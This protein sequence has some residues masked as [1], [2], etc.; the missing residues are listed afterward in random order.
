MEGEEPNVDA[1]TALGRVLAELVA[2]QL[3]NVVLHADVDAAPV[4]TLLDAIIQTR[5]RQR[6]Q[7]NLR[8][9]ISP[10]DACDAWNSQLMEDPVT[11]QVPV[12]DDCWVT[13]ELHAEVISSL[14]AAV[15]AAGR[16]GL[17]VELTDGTPGFSTLSQE[18][19]PRTVI[20]SFDCFFH[21]DGRRQHLAISPDTWQYVRHAW[22]IDVRLTGRSGASIL[23]RESYIFPTKALSIGD[24]DSVTVTDGES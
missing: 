18:P 14:S 7:A 20:A 24:G 1:G 3:S 17:L 21:I 2:D 22:S 4:H 8:N 23:L 19:G 10:E 16:H 9:D 15:L 6:L 12:A 13:F 5:K 11:R